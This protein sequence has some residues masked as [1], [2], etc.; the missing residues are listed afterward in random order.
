[1]LKHRWEI[2]CLEIYAKW[3][4]WKAKYVS[5][6]SIRLYSS[7]W[8][9]QIDPVPA[10]Y[11]VVTNCY[12]NNQRFWFTLILYLMKLDGTKTNANRRQQMSYL[13]S[14][15]IISLYF[16]SIVHCSPFTMCVMVA[17][18]QCTGTTFRADN[19][20]K[21]STHNHTNWWCLWQTIIY[22]FLYI[23]VVLPSHT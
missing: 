9:H 2:C 12:N 1:M 16:D 17:Q 13:T 4:I 21:S 7:G 19:R 3:K 18:Q 22:R 5:W 6:G 8:E 11:C 14:T 10:T 23:V 20:W 15:F